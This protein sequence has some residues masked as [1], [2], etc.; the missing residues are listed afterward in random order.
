VGAAPGKN[1]KKTDTNFRLHELFA[2]CIKVGGHVRLE[3]A[4]FDELTVNNVLF[5]DSTVG[6]EFIRCAVESILVRLAE[7][8]EHGRNC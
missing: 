1:G 4:S 3:V 7:T 5:A 6:N 8:D 2:E